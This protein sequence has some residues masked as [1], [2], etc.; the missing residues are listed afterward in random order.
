MRW[1][2]L[3]TVMAMGSSV[4]CAHVLYPESRIYVISEN[5]E[6]VGTALGSGGAGD[7]ICQEALEKCMKLCWQKHQWP[8]PHNKKQ[9]GWYYKRCTADCNKEFVECEEEYEEAVRERE[10][11][12]ILTRE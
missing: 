7:D 6:G 2:A 4:G 10:E 1:I 8:Y 11:T 9:S 12:G 5:S 3:M